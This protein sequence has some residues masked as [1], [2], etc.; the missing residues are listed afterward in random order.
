MKINIEEKAMKF[1]R[2]WC[3]LNNWEWPDDLDGKPDGFDKMS[4]EEKHKVIRPIMDDIDKTI[5]ELCHINSWYVTNYY[6]NCYHRE[7]ALSHD[8][9]IK[10]IL[11]G[12][13]TVNGEDH[14][15]DYGDN[16]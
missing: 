3:D 7:D 8:A 10:W 5:S 1:A 2:Q 14:Y 15:I 16:P 9:W 6:W 11:F 13:V 12:K 4:A